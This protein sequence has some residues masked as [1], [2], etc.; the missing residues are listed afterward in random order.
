MTISRTVF[1]RIFLQYI[2]I[3]SFNDFRKNKTD[4]AIESYSN[5]SKF[6]RDF[7]TEKECFHTKGVF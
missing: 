4:I 7:T 5:T 6:F 1:E 2:L 3:Q